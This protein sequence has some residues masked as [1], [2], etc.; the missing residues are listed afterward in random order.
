MSIRHF[1]VFYCRVSGL[2]NPH[3]NAYVRPDVA[4]SSLKTSSCKAWRTGAARRSS[5][6][7]SAAESVGGAEYEFPESHASSFALLAYVSSLVQKVFPCIR[8][9][10]VN[11][12]NFGD[13]L[14]PIIAEFDL[15]AHAALVPRQ[16]LLV[17]LE[18]A[19]RRYEAA[20]A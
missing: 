16:A 4:L 5:R 3:F 12:L 19:Q 6:Y 20:V 14:S 2:G 11:P 13:C 10:G 18:A 15:A 17:S 9:T 8:D 1:F 7:P